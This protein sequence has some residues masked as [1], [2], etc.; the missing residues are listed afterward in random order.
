M[1]KLPM[2]TTV[3]F[4]SVTLPPCCPVWYYTGQILHS[5]LCKINWNVIFLMSLGD[6]GIVGSILVPEPQIG[7]EKSRP[8]NIGSQPT[9]FSPTLRYAG[10]PDFCPKHR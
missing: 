2:K 9:F 4:V 5:F 8:E 7:T 6:S 3:L 1:I 10:S